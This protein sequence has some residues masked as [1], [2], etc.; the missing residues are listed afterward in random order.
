MAHEER[1][2]RMSRDLVFDYIEAARNQATSLSERIA[3]EEAE[4]LASDVQVFGRTGS[5][6]RKNLASLQVKVAERADEDARNAAVNVVN[7][8]KLI[9]KQLHLA[10][11]SRSTKY[12]K[13]VGVLKDGVKY[14]IGAVAVVV[15]TTLGV[16]VAV[17]AALVA[18]LLRLILKMGINAFCEGWNPKLA[19]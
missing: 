7:W 16:S 4:V 19:H 2:G 9:L 12:A 14:L 6:D 17:I 1:R 5:G 11:C 3:V 15:A 13:E 10:L 8:K 18:A